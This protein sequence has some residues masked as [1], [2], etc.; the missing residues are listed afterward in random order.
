M[1]REYTNNLLVW[2]G[3]ICLV[4][5]IPFL[6]VGI[7]LGGKAADQKRLDKEGQTVQGIVLSKTART[8]SSSRSS[9]STTSYY[10]TYRFQ[11]PAGQI[12]RGASST[13]H[14]TW[15]RLVE[16]GP[17]E[18]T[19]LSDAPEVSR[20][21]RD[22]EGILLF[23]IFTGLGGLALLIGIVLFPVGLRQAH[24]ARRLLH[25]GFPVEAVVERVTESNASFSGVVQWWIHYRYSDYQGRS[26]TGRSGYLPPEE[27]SL[28]RPGDKGRARYDERRPQESVWIGKE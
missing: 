6:C 4:V 25:S 7:W 9:S 26:W 3:G 19:Y 21:D 17:V 2:A 20:V 14:A 10:V 28:W 1:P 11:T 27:A 5:G 23:L 24:T 8:S 18:V 13:S 22:T 12:V 15:D 16:R